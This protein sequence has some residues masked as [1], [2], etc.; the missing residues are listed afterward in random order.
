MPYWQLFYHIVWATA[1]REPL[2]TPDIEPVIFGF[3]RG[4]ALGLGGAVFALNGTSTH[5]H[6]V[7]TIPPK[8]AVSKFVG[9]TKGVASTR[10]NKSGMRGAPLFWQGEY[11]V[12]S[13]D[14]KRLPQY[15][16]YVEGQKQHHASAKLIPILER[17]D[18]AGT[19]LVRE[20]PIQYVVPQDDW[21]EMMLALEQTEPP[22]QP[23]SSGAAR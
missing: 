4:K 13:F 5:V 18:D 17:T 6:M 9:Q 22:D 14:A 21:W 3:L 11:G 15:V 7:A 23:D 10:F 2:L 16:A 20:P 1:N 12:F 19:R 8:I